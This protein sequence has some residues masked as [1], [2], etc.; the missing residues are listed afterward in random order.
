MADIDIELLQEGNEFVRTHLKAIVNVDEHDVGMFASWN[1][2]CMAD[3]DDC[4]GD[5]LDENDLDLLLYSNE[6]DGYES[7]MEEEAEE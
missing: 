2:L 7:V 1:K 6:F 5:M 3:N 4:E